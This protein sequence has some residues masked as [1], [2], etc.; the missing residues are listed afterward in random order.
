[1]TKDFYII[2]NSGFAKEVLFL[3]KQTL[4]ESYLFKGFI[5]YKPKS[6]V[7]FVLN[8]EYSIIDEEVFLNTIKPNENILVF[9]GIGNPDIIK[10]LSILYKNYKTPNLIHPN[11][12]MHQNSVKFGIGNIVTSGCI[13]TVDIN[14]GNFNIFNLNSTIGHDTVIENFN[15]INPGVNISGGVHIKENNLI[16]TN[17]TILQ[18]ITIGSNNIIGASSLVNKNVDDNHVMVG[19]PAKPIK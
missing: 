4:N 2:G 3:A 5:D 6:N 7:I 14:I 11:V 10:K 17:A 9:I 13:F 18:Y 8:D 19:V 16:G 12:I 15:V 1:M